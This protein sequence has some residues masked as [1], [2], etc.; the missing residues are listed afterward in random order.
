MGFAR[1]AKPF[2]GW[3]AAIAAGVAATVIAAVLMPSDSERKPDPQARPFTIVS[4]SRRPSGVGWMTAQP[5]EKAGVLP[6]FTGDWDD[7]D[8]Q[9]KRWVD[10]TEAVPAIALNVDFTVQGTSEAEVTLTGLVVRVTARRPAFAGVHVVDMGAGDTPYR[11]VSADLDTDP[12]TLSDFF[13]PSFGSRVPANQ[14]RPI[15]FPYQVK[16]S[17]AESFEV[18]VRTQLC[19]CEFVIDL[20]WIALG[21]KGT[22]TIDDAGKPF[23]VAGTSAAV[24]FCSALPY[25]GFENSCRPA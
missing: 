4:E 18:Y 21:R 15:Q 12:P 14:L 17:D 24:H 22:A 7:L 2:G 10:Q 6:V 9:W 5:V 13:D 3:L 11:Y 8:E 1:R 19:D 25:P 16:I 23:R 20:T